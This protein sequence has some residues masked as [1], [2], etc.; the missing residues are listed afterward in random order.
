VDH[1]TLYQEEHTRAQLGFGLLACLR[2]SHPELEKQ[3]DDESHCR[4]NGNEDE[5]V[6]QRAGELAASAVTLL[7][8]GDRSRLT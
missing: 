4:D 7:H 2:V 8:R 5:S 1:R 6:E 3:H